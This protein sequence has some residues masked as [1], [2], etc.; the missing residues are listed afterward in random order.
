MRLECHSL[1]FQVIDRGR[2]TRYAPEEGT[3][4]CPDAVTFHTAAKKC[5][6]PALAIVK[7][8]FKVLFQKIFIFSY[9]CAG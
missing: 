7:V 4:H 1:L 8:S 9:Y 3:T 6:I 5:E 2:A